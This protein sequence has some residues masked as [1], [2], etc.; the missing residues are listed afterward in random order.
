VL[1]KQDL[2]IC[3]L[4]FL[5][6]DNSAPYTLYGGQ[7]ITL[8]ACSLDVCK[9][10]LRPFDTVSEP[11][12]CVSSVYYAGADNDVSLDDY[13]KYVLDTMASI[14][15]PF[16][17]F[18]DSALQWR[19]DILAARAGRPIK[20]IEKPLSEIPMWGYISRT[21]DILFDSDITYKNLLPEQLLLEWSKFEWMAAAAALNPYK[22]TQF[23]WLDAD[24]SRFSGAGKYIFDSSCGGS[25][26]FNIATVAGWENL[27]TELN[28]FIGAND[29]VIDCRW[30]ICDSNSLTLVKDVINEIWYED[31]IKK[32]RIVNLGVAVSIVYK[33]VP[34]VFNI[35]DVGFYDFFKPVFE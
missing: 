1:A 15:S 2:N 32:R 18:L 7:D 10:C 4:F 31:M 24:Y 22:S 16:V 13:K 20:I 21:T 19:N 9:M 8:G 34:E 12:T 30:F 3:A 5:R 35:K 28:K 26:Q 6:M 25:S 14:Q 27:I 17:L 11:A 33:T 23:V 29:N